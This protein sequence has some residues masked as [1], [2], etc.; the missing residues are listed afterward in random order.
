MV[1]S[2]LSLGLDGIILRFILPFLNAT[3]VSLVPA[4]G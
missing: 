3:L 2:C 1:Q 4:V